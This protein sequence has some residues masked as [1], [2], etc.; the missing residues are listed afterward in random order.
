VGQASIRVDGPKED[1]S[2]TVE[3]LDHIGRRLVIRTLPE[4]AD[5]LRSFHERMPYG[6]AV[7]DL[8]SL[9]KRASAAP[10]R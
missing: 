3:M 6:I 5:I 8:E 10:S 4:H 2:F 1:G 7:P 9:L